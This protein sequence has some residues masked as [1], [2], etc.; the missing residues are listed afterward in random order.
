MK[1]AIAMLMLTVLLGGCAMGGGGMM[2]AKQNP[3][4]SCASR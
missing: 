3:D 2:C 4:G 1:I